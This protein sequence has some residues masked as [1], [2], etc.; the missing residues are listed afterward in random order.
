M[1][2][3]KDKA[4]TSLASVIAT[5][6]VLVPIW[7]GVVKSAEAGLGLRLPRIAWTTDTDRNLYRVAQMEI[8]V[9]EN[10]LQKNALDFARNKREESEYIR[11]D[12]RPPSWLLRE[13]N[14]LQSR[15][16][17]LERRLDD[18]R[19]ILNKR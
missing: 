5:I 6:I 2:P 7:A 19:R 15:Q 14:A 16:R 8:W 1:W 17:E 18:A 12:Q 13:Q 11:R 10:A 3:S 9:Y 4:I